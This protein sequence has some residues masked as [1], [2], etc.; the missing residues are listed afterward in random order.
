M[1]KINEPYK[2]G[3]CTDCNNN[4]CGECCVENTTCENIKECD[5]FHDWKTE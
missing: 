3:Y 5:D 4:I 2:N 1:D